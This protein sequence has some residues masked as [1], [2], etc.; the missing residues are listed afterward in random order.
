[1]TT[2]WVSSTVLVHYFV[3][4]V[5]TVAIR[6]DGIADAVTAERT[7]GIRTSFIS[8]AWDGRTD[9]QM[10]GRSNKGLCLAIA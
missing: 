3:T 1:M 8:T 6:Y 10:D 2:N 9:G 7:V 4:V 5:T